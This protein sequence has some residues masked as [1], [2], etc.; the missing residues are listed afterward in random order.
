M[1]KAVRFGIAAAAL[2]G[3]APALAS[4]FSGLARVF[5][6]GILA[7]AV[8]IALVV[9]L[10]G[11]RRG[12]GTREGALILSVITAVTL[13]PALLVYIDEQWI[14]A[15]LPALAIALLDGSAR[16]LF[17]VPVFSMA[18]CAAIMFYLLGGGRK[19]SAGGDG[20]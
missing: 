1:R 5:W 10:I 20:E 11:R 4:D 15:P 13:A 2:C 17:P 19:K 8:L 9:T 14:P 16:L 6:W 18:I 12:Q 3:A 7:I